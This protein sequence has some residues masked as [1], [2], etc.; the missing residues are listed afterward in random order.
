MRSNGTRL[1]GEQVHT[2]RQ[3]ADS[4]TARHTRLA[5]HFPQH[6]C[7]A[8]RSGFRAGASGSRAR[9]PWHADGRGRAQPQTAGDT[10]RHTR[11]MHVTTR[12]RAIVDVDTLARHG[13]D[14]VA[15]VT[16]AR[17]RRRQADV[18][19]DAD[20]TA[21][22]V[23]LAEDD[24]RLR[25]SRRACWLGCRRSHDRSPAARVRG[26]AANGTGQPSAG[27]KRREIA[28][29]CHKVNPFARRDCRMHTALPVLSRLDLSAALRG[30]RG[31]SRAGSVGGLS[32][33]PRF[34]PHAGSD[35]HKDAAKGSTAASHIGVAVSLHGGDDGGA[36]VASQRSGVPSMASG[37]A[38][39][40]HG[41][42]RPAAKPLG[43]N[44]AG[45]RGH[46]T[47]AA[48]LSAV[49]SPALNASGSVSRA[50]VGATGSSTLGTLLS[51][52]GSTGDGGVLPRLMFAD[53][54]TSPLIAS[55]L[56]DKLILRA[57]A[58]DCLDIARRLARGQDINVTHSVRPSRRRLTL[59][60]LA[61]HS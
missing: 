8:L 9:T 43:A 26:R 57:A 48:S 17:P 37:R 31:D 45:A 40:R 55:P 59:T 4:S 53:A 46:V 11:C 25:T 1:P 30:D 56:Q 14:V 34:S 38:S 16:A 32:P 50:G 19:K 54:P 58:G 41:A 13:D 27:A 18:V 3:H 28:N 52:A 2:R 24:G 61:P 60:A 15:A 10:A 33:V 29:G 5:T 49:T 44:V 7:G 20:N 36:A 39:H 21:D 47:D 42:L 22:L 12:T 6:H 51:F 35:R 23:R